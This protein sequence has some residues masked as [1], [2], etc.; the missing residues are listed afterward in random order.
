MSNQ[1]SKEQNMLF[2]EQI[3]IYREK[4]YTNVPPCPACGEAKQI[5]LLSWINH[6]TWRC[7]RCRHK[8]TPTG[9]A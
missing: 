4:L 1:F 5:Q 3:A 6:V 9:A 8:W 7:R 2:A